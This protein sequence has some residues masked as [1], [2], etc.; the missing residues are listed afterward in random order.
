[1]LILAGVLRRAADPFVLQHRQARD[2]RH[3]A[4]GDL[5]DARELLEGESAARAAAGAVQTR[6]ARRAAEGERLCRRTEEGAADDGA[7]A[8][9]GGGVRHFFMFCCYI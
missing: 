7:G 5:A 1:M 3:G 9:Q 4:E 2:D 8:Q 6:G